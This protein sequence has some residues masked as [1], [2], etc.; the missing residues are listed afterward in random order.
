MVLGTGTLK[1]ASELVGETLPATAKTKRG[2]TVKYALIIFGGSQESKL[3][4]HSFKL[5]RADVR[6]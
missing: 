6:I 2:N 3:L 4:T 1:R 5:S